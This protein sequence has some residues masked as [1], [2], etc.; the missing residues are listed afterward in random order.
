MAMQ[1]D[2]V[3]P[4]I[5]IT[6][7]GRAEPFSTSGVSVSMQPI[8][9]DLA[10]ASGVAVT[11]ALKSTLRAMSRKAAVPAATAKPVPAGTP[12]ANFYFPPGPDRNVAPVIALSNDG[13]SVSFQ[14][15]ETTVA[16]ASSNSSGSVAFWK[17]PTYKYSAPADADSGPEPEIIST[18]KFEKYFPTAIRNF[19]PEMSFRPPAYAGDLSA[20]F[21]LDSINIPLDLANATKVYAGVR[22]YGKTEGQ[23]VA[24]AAAAAEAKAAAEAAA[25][26][27]AKANFK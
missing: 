11:A 3:A 25:Q 24:D 4:V 23:Y 20:Y 15:I 8:A 18:A 13:V 26:A 5:K 14:K 16:G 10:A 6:G 7:N 12:P 27:K 17:Q 19:V 1:S 2:S 22:K 21:M 9:A